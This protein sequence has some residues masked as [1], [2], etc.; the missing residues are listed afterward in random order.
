MTTTAAPTVEEVLLGLVYC[1]K[2]AGIRTYFWPSG[3]GIFQVQEGEL[4]QALEDSY[5]PTM[6]NW[7]AMVKINDA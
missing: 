2:E 7:P 3:P 6:P 1:Y 4:R 5:D